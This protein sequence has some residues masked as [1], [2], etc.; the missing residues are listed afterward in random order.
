METKATNPII[1]LQNSSHPIIK[2][3][4]EFSHLKQ[5]YRQGWLARGIPNEKC[6][7]VAEHTF[8]VAVTA[9]FLADSHFPELNSRKVMQMALIH[10]FGEIYAGDF[11]P[12]DAITPEEKHQL[13]KEAV[14]Q[15]LRDCRK[16]QNI[17]GCG[18]N[19]KTAHRP[20]PNSFVKSTNLKWHYKP[21]FMST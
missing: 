1:T 21:A 5:L 14:T 18:K 11:I 7:S 6:E 17:S 12:G 16:D 10:D 9:M 4:F 8:G 15:I 20:K 19:L 3:F 13:E 2:I